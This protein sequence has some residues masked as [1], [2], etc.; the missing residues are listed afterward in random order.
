MSFLYIIKRFASKEKV[1]YWFKFKWKMILINLLIMF[2]TIKK[3]IYWVWNNYK[4]HKIK[5]KHCGLTLF[6]SHG[7]LIAKVTMAKKQLLSASIL[8]PEKVSEKLSCRC[9]KHSPLEIGLFVFVVRVREERVY[10]RRWGF[11]S[12]STHRMHL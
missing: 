9:H 7:T 8:Y 10:L 3:I 11:R 6:D 1:Q 4:G 12:P 5:M 2:I